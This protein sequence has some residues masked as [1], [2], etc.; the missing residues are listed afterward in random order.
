[1]DSITACLIV[2][3]EA[4]RLAGCLA[5]AAPFVD[6]L[7]VLDTG[8]RDDTVAIALA[9][10]ARVECAPWGDDFAEARNAAL[11][12]CRTEWVLSLDADEQV[13]GTAAWIRPMLRACG[14]ELDAL[15]VS[16][17]NAG[18]PDAR[19]L[20][21]HR[22]VKLLRREALRWT[23]RVHE[24]PVRL[25]GREPVAAAL[26]DQTLRLVHHGYTDP[27]VVQAKAERNARLA[28]LSLLELIRLDAPGMDIARAALDVGRSELACGRPGEA[29]AA[30]RQ[31]RE[32]PLGSAIWQWATDFL[33]RL[34]LAS[35]RTD[36]ATLLIAELSRSGAPADYC[37]WLLALTL[38]QR[39]DLAGAAH[40]LS[41]IT[42][43]VDLNGN[44]L[45]AGQLEQARR[46]C[47]DRLAG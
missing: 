29:V 15:S 38:V 40:L 25:D 32:S 41:V 26:P 11:S 43:L 27:V 6:E 31:A 9:A 17:A 7:V 14:P 28:R 42:A 34:A 33:V 39:G 16:I 1:M 2:R 3:D 12:L 18:G 46:A 4:E 10:G 30:F 20:V 13:A 19:G 35:E 44:V 21:E 45:D 8:S 5:S 36:E 23:G 22:E 37:R 47:G 24:R